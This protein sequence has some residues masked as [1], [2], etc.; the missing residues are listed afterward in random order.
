MKI[1]VL[2]SGSSS[3]K[4]QYFINQISNVSLHI[5]RIGEECSEAILTINDKTE[6]FKETV[7]NHHE[8]LTLLFSLLKHQHILDSINT[9][10]AVGHRV[11]HGGNY[12][13]TAVCITEEVIKKITSLIPLA[14]LHNPANL[15]AIKSLHTQY[16]TLQQVAVFDTAFHQTMPQHAYTYP[17]PYEISQASHIRRYGFHGTSHA[18]VVKEAAV[19]LAKPLNRVNLITLHL[20]NGASAAA[21]QSG[22]SIDTSMGMTPL[23]G[24]M[25]GT[26]SGDI[27]PAIIPYLTRTHAL[28]LDDIDTLLNKESG[29]KG[30]CGTNDMRE[31]LEKVAKKDKQAT[32]AL[33]M[34]IYRILKYIGAYTIVLGRVDAIVFTGGIGEHAAE[35]RERVCKRL[36]TALDLQID[37]IKNRKK[38]RG[39]REIQKDNSQ[40]KLLVIPTNEE[41]EIVLQTQNILKTQ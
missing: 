17:L 39:N 28:S 38:L 19:C 24:L 2:N 31:V 40:I 36:S 3:L 32:L 23:E 4:C 10:D 13:N 29:L 9:L 41:L 27:D 20:G 33:E 16:P 12:F 26:R 34:Y 11:V 5:E 18:Y 21:I 8:A 30:I 37:P 35:L 6:S 15:E 7:N 22:K 14:P 1:L 25:M